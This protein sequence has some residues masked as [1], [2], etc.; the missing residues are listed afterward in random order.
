M[1]V[2]GLRYICTFSYY[3]YPA[4]PDGFCEIIGSSSLPS[5]CTC[6]DSS[7]GGTLDCDFGITTPVTL[8]LKFK[9]DFLPCGQSAK[10]N[11]D[12]TLNGDS[13]PGFPQGVSSGQS[14]MI[15]IPGAT[16][17]AAGGIWLQVDMNGNV[18]KLK[19]KMVSRL[20]RH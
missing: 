18:E 8:D 5:E 2:S 16:F 3:L 15:P 19:V 4:V 20:R 12:L 9:F 17:P 13:V 14:L 1:L 6:T 11:I 7:G 10:I